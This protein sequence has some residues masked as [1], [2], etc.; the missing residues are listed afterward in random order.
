[1]FLG[2]LDI[3]LLGILKITCE[4]VEVQQASKKFDSYTMEPTDALN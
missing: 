3:E 1:M 4:V 2:M